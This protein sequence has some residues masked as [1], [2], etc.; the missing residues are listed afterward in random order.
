MG[1]EK[2]NVERNPLTH[3]CL[4]ALPMISAFQ[5][6]ANVTTSTTMVIPV[7]DFAPLNALKI[8]SNVVKNKLQPAAYKTTSVFTKD[9]IGIILS[10]VMAFTPTGSGLLGGQPGSY[11][12]P[13]PTLV[14]WV[15]S[16]APIIYPNRLWFAG[17]SARLLL[18]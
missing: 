15:V 6:N 9:L 11:C 1:K 7:N 5:K 14:R 4:S 17:W 12:I 2:R 3:K 13:Q 16:Q 8:K 10:F 18:Y